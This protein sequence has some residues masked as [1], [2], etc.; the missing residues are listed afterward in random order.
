M[1]IAIQNP[2][3]QADQIRGME[4]EIRIPDSLGQGKDHEKQQGNDTEEDQPVGQVPG[5]EIAFQLIDLRDLRLDRALIHD[6]SA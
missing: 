6:T 4:D 5:F 2:G 3:L 1:G